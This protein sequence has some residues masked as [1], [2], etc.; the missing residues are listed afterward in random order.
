MVPV[1][2]FESDPDAL[3]TKQIE[4]D[5]AAGQFE[6]VVNSWK[7]LQNVTVETLKM[8]LR[9]LMELD[10]QAEVHEVVQTM[11]ELNCSLRTTGAMNSV[12]ALVSAKSVTLGMQ[13]YDLFEGMGVASNDATFEN[14]LAGLT[15]ASPE[16]AAEVTSHMKIKMTAR[17]YSLLIK[18]AIKS[19][20]I[21][22]ALSFVAAMHEAGHVIPPSCLA[23]IF[24]S[25]GEMGCLGEVMKT[26]PEG[27][28]YPAEA[29]G[30]ILE[31]AQKTGNMELL[32]ATHKKALEEKVEDRKSTRLNSSH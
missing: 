22:R 23:V 32:K 15:D 4:A 11:L 24:R 21:D 25:A 12:L 14:I 18:R 10:R 31:S 26:L 5:F 3:R 27:I 20:R 13:V 6:S 9:S 30:S 2:K 8:V 7:D 19:K 28:A 16:Q 17:V 29:V 1:K